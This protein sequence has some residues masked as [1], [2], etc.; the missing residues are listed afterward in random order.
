MLC[1]VKVNG[2]R[3]VG[4]KK[5]NGKWNCVKIYFSYKR[6]T[7][8]EVIVLFKFVSLIFVKKLILINYMSFFIWKDKLVK[9]G[10][11]FIY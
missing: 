9:L 8:A 7:S 3:F 10:N 4:V 2:F 6:F 1:E 5:Q 11:R